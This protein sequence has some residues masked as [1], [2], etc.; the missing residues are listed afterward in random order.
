M[1][2][3]PHLAGDV[4]YPRRYTSDIMIS[5]NAPDYIRL[6]SHAHT[7]HTHAGQLRQPLTRYLS[8]IGWLAKYRRRWLKA[9]LTD[10]SLFFA[11]ALLVR[12][13]ILERRR[14]AIPEPA[15]VVLD[16]EETSERDITALDMLRDLLDHLAI[17]PVRLY[18]SFSRTC[19]LP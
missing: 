17:Q 16:I 2:R 6:T 1:R 15:A 12:E 7:A 13:S 3:L 11:N 8:I 19:L 4:S 9:D 14:M 18:G 5:F 10:G